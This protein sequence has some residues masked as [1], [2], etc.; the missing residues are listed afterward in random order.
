MGSSCS[1]VVEAIRKASGENSKC[2][3]DMNHDIKKSHFDE[4]NFGVD[5]SSG[6]CLWA[7]ALVK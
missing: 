4:R 7:R 1:L 5:F 6:H 3:L 2:S